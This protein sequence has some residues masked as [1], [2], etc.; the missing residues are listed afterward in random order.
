[1]STRHYP[2][3]LLQNVYF[4]HLY[5]IYYIYL[6]IYNL[7]YIVLNIFYQPFASFSRTFSFSIINYKK[8]TFLAFKNYIVRIITDIGFN[9]IW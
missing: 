1:M 9:Y 5:H 2:H 3:V 8:Y 7:T 6:I 4:L